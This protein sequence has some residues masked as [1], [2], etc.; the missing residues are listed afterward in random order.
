MNEVIWP[1][2]FPELETERLL[3]RRVSP[4]D[5]QGIFECFQAH[6]R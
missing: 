3:L 1:L 5:S 6:W 4:E 2:E